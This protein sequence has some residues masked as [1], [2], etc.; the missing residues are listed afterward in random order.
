MRKILN[1]SKRKHCPHVLDKPSDFL[2]LFLTAF[3]VYGTIGWIMEF[4]FNT[5]TSGRIVIPGYLTIMPFLPIYGFCGVFVT[6]TVKYVIAAINK[7]FGEDTKFDNAAFF[8][9]FMIVGTLLELV[10]G[11]LLHQLLDLRIWDYSDYI[12]NINGYVCF[13]FSVLFGIGGVI[14]MNFIFYPVDEFIY[15]TDKTIFKDI[16]F[17]LVPIGLMDFIYTTLFLL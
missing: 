17:I 4:I 16:L 10:G 3:L 15:T 12:F 8:L 1:Q 5:L 13:E 6:F 9:Y 11:F 7:T 14:T 2:L